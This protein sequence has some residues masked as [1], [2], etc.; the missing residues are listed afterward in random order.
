MQGKGNKGKKVRKVALVGLLDRQYMH[1]IELLV[2][3]EPFFRSNQ[4]VK[5][6]ANVE[7][8]LGAHPCFG[9][10]VIKRSASSVI[11]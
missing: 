7:A 2:S 3:I 8:F 6:T 10:N 4:E 1:A 5:T 9:L 11:N